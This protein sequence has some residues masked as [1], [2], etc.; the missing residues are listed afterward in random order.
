ME[1]Q[2]LRGQGSIGYALT[3][4]Q[5]GAGVVAAFAIGRATASFRETAAAP[6]VVASTITTTRVPE[7]ADA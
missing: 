2:S 6:I 5:L 3:A 4:I 7:Q 1:T